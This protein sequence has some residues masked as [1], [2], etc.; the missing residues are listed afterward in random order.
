[1]PALPRDRREVVKPGDVVRVKVLSVDVG[2][3]RISLA[4]RLDD[5]EAPGRPP[6]GATDD[7]APGRK[8][9]SPRLNEALM[10]LI[11]IAMRVSWK[12]A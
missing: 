9:V 10:R 3:K 4:L 7:A 1:M 8:D 5:D 2:R 12:D 11:R 6:G